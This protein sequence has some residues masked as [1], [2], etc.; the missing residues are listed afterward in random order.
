MVI[1]TIVV[2]EKHSE[3][4]EKQSRNFNFSKFIRAKL[5]EYIEER[6]QGNICVMK[7][8]ERRL[9]KQLKKE[10]RE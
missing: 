8:I 6:N 9:E 1:K 10:V 4:I 5:D 2:S 3:F 7:N